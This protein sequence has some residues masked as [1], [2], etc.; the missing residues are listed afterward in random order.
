MSKLQKNLF[1]NE[2]PCTQSHLPLTVLFV[3]FLFAISSPLL[4]SFKRCTIPPEAT[5]TL[6]NA[7]GRLGS[8]SVFE[9]AFSRCPGIHVAPVKRKRTSLARMRPR[10]SASG[11]TSSSPSSS[12]SSSESLSVAVTLASKQTGWL[13]RW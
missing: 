10:P 9:K 11:D 3:L 2:P 4:P 7:P 5:P 6:R 12:S 1:L 8:P 13:Y